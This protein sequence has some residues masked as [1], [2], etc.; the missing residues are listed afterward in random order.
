MSG[1]QIK[2]QHSWVLFFFS[3]IFVAA[4]ALLPLDVYA[5]KIVIQDVRGEGKIRVDSFVDPAFPSVSCHL[6]QSIVPGIA[7]AVGSGDRIFAV[8]ISCSTKT[9]LDITV[10]QQERHHGEEVYLRET[11]SSR[12]ALLVKRYVDA[13]SQ[14]LVYVL[15]NNKVT[16]EAPLVAISSVDF[17]AIP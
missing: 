14:K 15:Y 10:R 12:H 2:E 11:T 6:V 3:S 9:A 7:K 1:A 17:N 16:G 8:D 5:E 4:L 13:E